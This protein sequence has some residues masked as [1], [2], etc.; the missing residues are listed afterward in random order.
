VPAWVCAWDASSPSN[1]ASSVT[2]LARRSSAPVETSAAS[3]AGLAP[4]TMKLASGSAW[5]TA[6]SEGSVIQSCAEAAAGEVAI[7]GC[8]Q[9]A[10]RAAPPTPYRPNP[11]C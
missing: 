3:V 1:L 8:G 7:H 6:A 9:G 11:W 4:L 2:P 10:R 5:K